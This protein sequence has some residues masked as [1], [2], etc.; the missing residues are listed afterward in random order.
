[1]CVV[2]KYFL[3]S[4]FSLYDLLYLLNIGRTKEVVVDLGESSRSRAHMK[5]VI[6]FWYMGVHIS[7]TLTF[8]WQWWSSGFNIWDL[9]TVGLWRIFTTPVILVCL[10]SGKCLNKFNTEWLRK[11]YLPQTIMVNSD[12]W[13][14]SAL[15][16]TKL[17][18]YCMFCMLACTKGYL[19][20]YLWHLYILRLYKHL[21]SRH[22]PQQ[23]AL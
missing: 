9:R 14:F 10:C 1:M 19:T 4:V 21:C 22:E 6:R 2:L 17:H 11:S 8:W 13:L 18:S 23:Y 16:Y 7:E 15:L 5:R 12:L 3:Y 20:L